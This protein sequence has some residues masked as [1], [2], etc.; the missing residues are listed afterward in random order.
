M[1]IMN[2]PSGEA[3]PPRR[4]AVVS[5]AADVLAEHGPD[6]PFELIAERAGVGRDTLDRHFPNRVVL[7]EAVLTQYVE[8]LADRTRSW[9][10]EADVFLWFVEQL[11]DF[12]VRTEGLPDALQATA[13]ETLES[14]RRTIIEVGGRAL[15]DAQVEGL[16]RADVT[17]DDIMMIATLLRAGLRGDLAERRALSLRTRAIVLSGLKAHP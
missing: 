15:R 13:P 4:R 3:A 1:A 10:G 7:T 8:D 9:A 16:V 17:P 11:A 12:F 6:A 2:F 5:A 14:L